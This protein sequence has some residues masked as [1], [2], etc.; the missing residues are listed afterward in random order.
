MVAPMMS[1]ARNL[2]MLFGLAALAGPVPAAAAP[3]PVA[4]PEAAR[5]TGERLAMAVVA[6]R[7]R[8]ESGRWDRRCTTDRVH[9][10]TLASYVPDVCR[11]IEAV[12]R[13]AALDPNFLARLIWKESLFDASAVS[14][15]GA[16]GI[17]QFMPETAKRRG[18]I[19][20]F[21]PAEALYVSA[22]YLSDLRRDY[23]NIGLAAAAYNG[24][25]ARVER[26]IAGAGELA[27]ETRAYVEAITGHPAETWRDAPPRAPDLAL[28]AEGTF[29]T[30]CIAQAA[31]HGLREFRSTPPV[32]P[33]GV[34]VA[35]NR[36][37]KGA[38]RQVERLRNRHAA[39]LRG[40]PVTYTR[41][42]RP[43]MPGSLYFAQIGRN[44]RADA[45][46]LCG[47]LQAAGAACIVLRN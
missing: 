43:G 17:A 5:P 27:P 33:W 46:A 10:I 41:R 4:R 7:P 29:Q 8:S 18:L 9:C 11:T 15:G 24:G 3:A 12:A 38:E 13:E 2:L 16:Q 39:V 30:A 28:A 36:E 45:E 21:N 37:S 6:P 26:F 22:R 42:K 1:H 20:A 44:T 32:M 40:E 31:D 14:P 47:R 25:P 35:S 34:F 23:G 19:D